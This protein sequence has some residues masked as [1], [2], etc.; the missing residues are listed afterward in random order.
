MSPFSFWVKGLGEGREG[1]PRRSRRPWSRR[2][3]WLTSGTVT[4]Q[5]DN[6]RGTKKVALDDISCSVR[7]LAAARAF[8]GAALGAIGMKVNMDV[9]SAFG[10]GAGNEKIFWLA[11]DRR[12]AG[13]GWR[14]PCF[15]RRS[16]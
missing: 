9:G 8:Y 10:M 4:R 1:V 13:G 5:R 6:P 11:R 7:S 12:A 15:P 2:G 16:R 3:S 14:S